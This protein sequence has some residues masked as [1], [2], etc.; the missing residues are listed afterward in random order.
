MPARR[1]H[2]A[3]RSILRTLLFVSAAFLVWYA[4]AGG[5]AS[6]QRTLELILARVDPTTAEAQPTPEYMLA[7]RTIQADRLAPDDP[8]VLQFRSALDALAPKCKESR[9]QLAMAVTDAHAARLGRGVEI[10]TLTLLA[11]VDA[12]LTEQTRSTW[13]RNCAELMARL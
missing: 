13:P 9:G 8:L 7:S 3:A 1:T 10:P 4:L 11:Q 6:V 12:A 5:E 2:G